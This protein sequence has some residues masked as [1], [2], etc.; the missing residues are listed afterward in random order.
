MMVGFFYFWVLNFVWS[1]RSLLQPG[2]LWSVRLQLP[3]GLL[4]RQEG[5][6]GDF[7]RNMQWNFC[8][9]EFFLLKVMGFCKYLVNWFSFP[10]LLSPHILIFSE[11]MLRGRVWPMGK[12]GKIKNTFNIKE[13]VRNHED[14]FFPGGKYFF[15]IIP[16]FTGKEGLIMSGWPRNLLP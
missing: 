10:V 1:L 5:V 13:F 11:E 8:I 7:A 14:Y 15:K 12:V 9:Y 6:K 3:V 2:H 16:S 4:I